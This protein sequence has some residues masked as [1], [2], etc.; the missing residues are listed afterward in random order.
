MPVTVKEFDKNDKIYKDCTLSVREHQFK[1]NGNEKVA[2]NAK[3]S[4]RTFDT[5]C[6]K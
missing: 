6:G 2:N 1:I 3:E 4:V 5:V